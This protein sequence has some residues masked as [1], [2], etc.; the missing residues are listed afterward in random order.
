MITVIASGAQAGLDHCVCQT[1]RN[2]LLVP[3]L[4]PSDTP[5]PKVESA[6]WG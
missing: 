1:L 6:L 5:G 3:K 2:G 4:L